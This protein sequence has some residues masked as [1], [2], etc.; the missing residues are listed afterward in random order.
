MSKSAFFERGGSVLELTRQ[1]MLVSVCQKT[2]GIPYIWY[3]NIGGL[4][5]DAFNLSQ[6]TRVTD[7]Q[8]EGTSRITT[9]KTAQALLRRAVRS[10][11]HILRT[12]TSRNIDSFVKS[13][14]QIT[15]DTS[16]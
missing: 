16:C 8:R 1:P 13:V 14:T 3:E 4:A 7:R 9:P 6:S 5:V 10:K 15:L 2:R 11:N 12:E